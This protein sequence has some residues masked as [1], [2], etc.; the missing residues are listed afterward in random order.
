MKLNKI[1]V[2]ILGVSVGLMSGYFLVKGVKVAS[3]H[4]FN[5]VKN[6]DFK[7]E[8]L[9]YGGPELTQEILQEKTNEGIYF[10]DYEKT[11]RISEDAPVPLLKNG[12]GLHYF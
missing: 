6:I 1:I 10:L 9:S 5:F 3:V 8:E 2:L 12:G 7:N 11:Y 4:T